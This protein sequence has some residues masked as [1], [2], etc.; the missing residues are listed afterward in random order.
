MLLYNDIELFS[1][2]E[3]INILNDLAKDK[4][5]VF[6][7]YSMQNELYPNLIRDTDYT[8]VENT[9]LKDFEHYGS[10]YFQAFTPIDFM[11]Y[12]QHYGLP[13]RLLDFTYNPFIALSFALYNPKGHNI[14]DESDKNYYYVRYA[15][16]KNGDNLVIK[17]SPFD[18]EYNM[19]FL[20]SDS[21]A[22]RACKSINRITD[23]YTFPS[24]SYYPSNEYQIQDWNYQEDQDKIRKC[25]KNNKILFIDPNQTNQRII[26]Q[27]GLFMFPYTISNEKYNKEKQNKEKHMDILIK[28]SSVIKIHKSL[29]EELL[30]YLDTLGYNTFR[31][32]PDL[33][34]VCEAIKN[35]AK[36]SKTKSDKNDRSKEK[37]YR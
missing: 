8:D 28:N 22:N 15:S 1:V 11:S 6:R 14:K 19:Q 24:N 17:N 25:I 32:M 23:I 29:Q 26:M 20:S 36:K 16:I 3:V 2:K 5:Y 35:K 13:T 31:L 34:S 9:L 33:S 27:Q 12:A 10:H 4:S 37:V 18:E 21:L 7:G 30:D